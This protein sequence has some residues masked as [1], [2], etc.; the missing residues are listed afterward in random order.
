[1]SIKIILFIL[2]FAAPAIYSQ[3]AVDIKS[4]LPEEIFLN[5]NFNK[6]ATVDSIPVGVISNLIRFVSSKKNIFMANPDK[7]FNS[8]DIID[9]ALPNRRLILAGRSAKFCFIYYE[10]GGLGYHTTFVMYDCSRHLPKLVLS[11]GTFKMLNSI[12]ELKSKIRE[13]LYEAVHSKG[14][15][16]WKNRINDPINL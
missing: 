2:Y 7:P 4:I 1:M 12:E 3:Q 6:I 10:C 11:F 5:T 16:I 14:K 9:N 15:E 13:Y 8:T